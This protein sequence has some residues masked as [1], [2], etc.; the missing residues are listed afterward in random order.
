MTQPNDFT[1]RDSGK[2]EGF[3]GGAVRD[4]RTGK[5]RYDL[6]SPF[7]LKRLALVYE[8]GCIK[9]S[10]RNWEKGMPFSRCLDSAIR[11][12]QQFLEGDTV[13]DHLAQ[14][15]WNLFAVMHFQRT[16]PELN[17]LPV[18]REESCPQK[19]SSNGT[20]LPMSQ[21]EPLSYTKESISS[22]PECSGGNT[23]QRDSLKP[24]SNTS[25]T[26]E[27]QRSR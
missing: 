7:A 14:A 17:D 11:H 13:E 5:G 4:V 22:S 23:S 18:F 19:E 24:L 8:R 3:G 26:G 6:I 25:K 20:T 9:Y 15:A 21:S 12:I 27:I 1:L 2:R 16:K 10:P